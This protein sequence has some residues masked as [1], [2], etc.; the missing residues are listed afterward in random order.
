MDNSFTTMLKQLENRYSKGYNPITLSWSPHQ[1]VEGGTPTLGYG[2]KMTEKELKSKTVQ[3][4]GKKFPL[5]KITT[6]DAEEIFKLDWQRSNKDAEK[7]IGK[8]WKNLDA[9]KQAVTAELFFNMGYTKASQFKNYKE[10]LLANDP[11][12]IDEINRKGVGS[13]VNAIKDWYSSYQ[14]KAFNDSQSI[15]NEQVNKIHQDIMSVFK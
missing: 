7:W 15:D 5:S 3:V 12:F 13:R 2:H 1:S 9:A 11:N 14:T 6:K 10:K 8:E 4:E